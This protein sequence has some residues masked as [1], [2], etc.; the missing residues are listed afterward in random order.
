MAEKIRDIRQEVQELGHLYINYGKFIE[1]DTVPAL[2]KI[3]SDLV[4]DLMQGKAGE[5]M[6][7]MISS[8]LA[9]NYAL[10]GEFSEKLGQGV[11]KADADMAQADQG[12]K[13]G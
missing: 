8:Y 12:I 13:F 6:K 4:N 10:L 7:D 5:V 11:L 9:K 1:Q 2:N 3:A